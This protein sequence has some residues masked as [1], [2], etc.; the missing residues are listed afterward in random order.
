M[1]FEKSLDLMRLAEMSA[2]RYRGVSLVDIME[3]FDVNQRTA[4]RMIRGLELVFPDLEYTT[5]EDR[6]RWWKLQDTTLLRF[7]GLRDAELTA[8]SMSIRRATRDDAYWDAKALSSLRDRLLAGMPSTHA[9]RAETDASALL[10]AQGFACRPGPRAKVEPKVLGTIATGIKGPFSLDILY[11]GA[12]DAEPMPRQVE[13]YGVLL[14]LRQYLIARDIKKGGPYRRFRTDRITDAQITGQSFRR[15]PD[16]NIEDYAA[17]S[18]GS[19]YSE[20]EYGPVVWRFSPYAADTAREF[21]FHPTQTV[22]EQP[23][24][25]LLV[26]FTAGGW[27]EMA[28]HFVKWG[29]AVEVL[30]PPE[31]KE[32]LEW[33]RRGEADIWP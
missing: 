1:A 15:D 12:R 25:G 7:Q 18:F 3:E 5:D 27:L 6:R 32:I 17:R 20:A 33:V 29:K 22:T 24:G 9:R 10:E 30:D 11:Q 23:D 31:L 13:P 26:E 4:Q 28:W 16:F 21:E 19:F 2:A 14:G 8:L